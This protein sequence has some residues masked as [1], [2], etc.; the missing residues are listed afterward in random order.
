MVNASFANNPDLSLQMGYVI[1]L[2]NE[3]ATKESFEFT[4]NIIHWF[5]VKC[6]RIT[7]SVLA[8]EVYAI[9]EGVN[10]A[11]AI[12][13]TINKFVAKLGAPSVSIV[14]YTNFLSLYE[15]LVKL[16]TIKEKR[17]IIDIMA[18]R[19][20]YERQKVRNIRWINN[21]NNPADAITK[22]T[23][24]HAFKKFININRLVL[25]L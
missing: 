25:R 18:I 9:A 19:Q 2:G 21:K 15:C 16:G 23:P 5:F 12:G 6:K 24:N 4:S 20:A 17:L 10:M 8:L 14:I 13:I 1:V 3:R 7:R 11:V 22:G